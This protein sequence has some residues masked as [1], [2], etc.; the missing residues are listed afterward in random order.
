MAKQSQNQ[1]TR[2]PNDSYSS[3]RKESSPQ[4]EES[5]NDTTHNRRNEPENC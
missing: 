1:E 3:F 4:E 5:S 2:D